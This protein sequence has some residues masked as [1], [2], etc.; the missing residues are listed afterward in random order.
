MPFGLDIAKN[1]TAAGKFSA[2]KIVPI[3]ASSATWANVPAEMRESAFF[4]AGVNNARV[5]SAAYDKI[6]KELNLL[7][8]DGS[9][10]DAGRFIAEMKD[11]LARFGYATDKSSITELASSAR[12]KLIHDM[13]IEEAHGYAGYV[14][15]QDENSLSVFPA[16][17]LV[18]KEDRENKRDWIQ[19]WQDC[20]GQLCGERGDRM[21]ALKTDPIW[22]AISRFGRPWPPFDFN[23][24]MGLRNISQREAV[25]LGLIK[26]GERVK[27]DPDNSF[28][29]PRSADAFKIN[30]NILKEAQLQ[31][32][33]GKIEDGKVMARPNGAPVSNALSN[34]IKDKATREEVNEAIRAINTVNGDGNLPKIKIAA[35]GGRAAG[36]YSWKMRGGKALIEIKIKPGTG[37]EAMSAVHEIW[38]FIDHKGINPNSERFSSESGEIKEL[39]DAL[40][41][42]GRIRQIKDEYLSA[43]RSEEGKVKRK[44]CAYLLDEREMTARAYA[45]FVAVESQSPQLLKEL[46]FMQNNPGWQK[47]TWEEED[48][49]EIRSAMQ[50]VLKRFGWRAYL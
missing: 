26:N 20:G 38:H 10:Y 43:D 7:K 14:N 2:R 6:Q 17:E 3:A 46:E 1:L 50:L 18:R 13:A 44:R 41:N 16:Q 22:A 11:E 39:I 19:R 23:S 37:T 36:E 42:S 34:T 9:H 48:F 35:Y 24:G 45:Q 21:V 47:S 12:L 49:K 28:I 32:A 33:L 40:E 31:G 30:E 5:L 29:K 27:P 15:G 25:K 8:V 4:S